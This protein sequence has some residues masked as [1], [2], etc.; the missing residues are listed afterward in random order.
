MV[1]ETRVDGRAVHN[2]Q[3]KPTPGIAVVLSSVYSGRGLAETLG[4]KGSKG[5]VVI[6]ELGK[7]QRVHFNLI[8]NAMFISDAP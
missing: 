5:S 6:T 1:A 7:K 8:D 2:N 4:A 3:L